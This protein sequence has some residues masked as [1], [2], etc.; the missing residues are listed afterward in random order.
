MPNPSIFTPIVNSYLPEPHASL[1]NGIIFGIPL[2]TNPLF[3][4]K[5]R[6]VGLM[7]LVVLSGMNITMV[8]AIVASFT[9][10][11]PKRISLYICITSII[12]FVLFVG[13]QAPVLRAAIMGIISLLAIIYGRKNSALYSLF[14][15]FLFFLIFWRQAIATVSF[16][17]S[18]G[19]TL[20]I[21]LFGN[22]KAQSPAVWRE[23]K[24]SLAAQLFTTPIIFAYFRQISFIAPISNLLTAFIIAP[25]MLFGFLTAILGKINWFL[26]VPA[27]AVSYVL[28]GYLV[29]IIDILSRIPYVYLK[30]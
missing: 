9:K 2:K 25:I 19:A 15:S 6:I 29:W 22:A 17:L 18:F 5:L 27:A 12:L 8:A 20:G 13:I 14:L 3:N 7:H 24:P 23:L 10:F 11:L 28:V 1:L 26:G 16:Q 4:Q 21:I 30:F